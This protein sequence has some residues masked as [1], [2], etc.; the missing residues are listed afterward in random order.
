MFSTKQGAHC[1][2]CGSTHTYLEINILDNFIEWYCVRCQLVFLWIA[3]KYAI[4]R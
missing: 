3:E 1:S 4:Q 2:L